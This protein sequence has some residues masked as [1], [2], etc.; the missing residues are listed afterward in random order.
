M[1]IDKEC[2]P[3]D[4][5]DVNNALGREMRNRQRK[6]TLCPNIQNPFDNCYCV[7]TSSACAEATIHFCGGSYKDCEIYAKNLLEGRRNA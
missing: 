6:G 4:P 2:Y 1:M 7:S 3:E 5:S